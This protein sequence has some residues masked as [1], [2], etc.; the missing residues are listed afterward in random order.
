[1]P[2]IFK[3]AL[4]DKKYITNH[5][6]FKSDLYSLGLILLEIQLLRLGYDNNEIL[7]ILSSPELAY[8]KA[9]DIDINMFINK[10]V[11]VKILD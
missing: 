10:S 2:P 5:D 8:E 1:M 3:N 9:Q 11:K 7:N 6:P 4:R